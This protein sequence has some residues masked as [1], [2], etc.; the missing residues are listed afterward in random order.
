MKKVTLF[1][2]ACT[3]A[4]GAVAKTRITRLNT[5]PD[6][7]SI[8]VVN[9]DPVF[10]SDSI[11][12]LLLK[13]YSAATVEERA[14]FVIDP[15][16]V[17][18]L[19]REYYKGGIRPLNKFYHVRGERDE[20]RGKYEKWD[21]AIQIGPSLI[22]LPV[23]LVKGRE[24]CHVLLRTP[25]GIKL[26]WEA[27]VQ[28]GESSDYMLTA[29]NVG[30]TFTFHCD[31]MN[32]ISSWNDSYDYVFL[33]SRTSELGDFINRYSETNSGN[34]SQ[35]SGHAVF[36]KDSEVRKKLMD[37]FRNKQADYYDAYYCCIV[38]ATVFDT[39][40]GWYAFELDDIV[41]E[42]PSRIMPFRPKKDNEPIRF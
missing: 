8:Q 7:E 5:Q 14:K 39:E 30:R 19:M 17:I 34:A 41:S 20:L 31:I 10:L 12:E 36:L 24:V 42:T 21:G 22:Y 40:H 16:N 1:V 38:K 29:D 27:T 3:L 37:M 4:F 9:D 15:K 26:D 28:Y 32:D 35:T 6:G 18:P 25:M 23:E 11:A 13:F 33:N 2:L